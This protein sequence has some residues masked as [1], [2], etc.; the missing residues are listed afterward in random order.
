M[1]VNLTSGTAAQNGMVRKLMNYIRTK[2]GTWITSRHPSLVGDQVQVGTFG[3]SISCTG[4]GRPA[5]KAGIRAVRGGIG[6][7]D[8]IFG[9]AMSGITDEWKV[10]CGASETYRD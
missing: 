8:L 9:V 5:Q 2:S 1:K 7:F 3:S 4:A 6:P 10:R